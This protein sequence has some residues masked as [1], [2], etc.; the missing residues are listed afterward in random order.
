MGLSS[1]W[2]L[3]LP[4]FLFI[5]L[6]RAFA[7]RLVHQMLLLPILQP[8]RRASPSVLIFSPK[9]PLWSHTFILFFLLS[10]SAL[11]VLTTLPRNTVDN[12]WG[13]LTPLDR[14]RQ[15]L[16]KLTD[17]LQDTG[18]LHGFLF[19]SRHWNKNLKRE[20]TKGC[21]DFL[22]SRSVTIS[23]YFFKKLELLLKCW[24]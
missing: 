2:I 21:E 20:T 13:F 15:H 16:T 24:V 4:F 19:A 11:Q 22:L 18:I 1:H 7:S 14:L 8:L 9:R 17:G 23:S 5:F 10:F 6:T 12:L 3:P